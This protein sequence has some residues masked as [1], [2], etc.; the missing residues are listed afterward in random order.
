M[1]NVKFLESFIVVITVLA[2]QVS[3]VFAAPNLITGTV[4]SITLETSVDTAVTTVLIT[5]VAN[6]IL[7]TV[8]VNIDSAIT[9]GL[10]VLGGDGNPVINEAILGQLVEIDSSTI[11]EDEL[12]QHPV[13]D[14]LATFFSDIVDLDYETI[15]AVHN[16][17]T[18]FGVIAQAL[19]LTKKLNGNAELFLEIID[20]KKTKD[21][22]TFL[23]EDGTSPENWGQFKKAV[24][25][26][27][28]EKPGVVMS[29]KNNNENSNAPGRHNGNGKGKEKNNRD[30]ENNGKGDG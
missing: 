23:F 18:G 12:H 9:L 16:E 7:Q 30:K 8:R 25:D 15:M 6:G 26:G 20:A 14:A 2:G 1:K 10:V 17:G 5:V 19:W 24:M 21:F 29:I 3:A 28:E 22:S 27:T 11:I 13:G 4:Q